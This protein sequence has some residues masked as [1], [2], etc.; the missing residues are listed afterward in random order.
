MSQEVCWD[1][2]EKMVVIHDQI[3]VHSGNKSM[4]KFETSNS[5]M[6]FMVGYLTK[7]V[8]YIGEHGR[9]WEHYVVWCSQ[10]YFHG[11][12]REFDYSSLGL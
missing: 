10:V 11:W 7:K 2:I 4:V 6:C 8:V 9:E 3:V 12:L 5:I 1:T